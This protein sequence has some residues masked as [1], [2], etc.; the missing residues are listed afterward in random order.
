MAEEL[1]NNTSTQGQGSAA[2]TE[3]TP[4]TYTEAELQSEVD[5]RVT[6]AMKTAEKKNA[7]KVKE[8]ERLATMNADERYKYDLEQREKAIAEKEKAL[9]MAENKNAACKVLADKGLDL[10][11]VDFVVDESADVMND[12]IKVLERA[13]RNSVKAEVE[14]R[15]GGKSPAAGTVPTGEI[16]KETFKKMGL[17]ERENLYNTDPE[18]YKKLKS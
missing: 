12:R 9:A 5:R 16:T 4:K 17:S 14:K 3:N 10:S 13:F 7:E 18:L 11:L 6:Q 15:I 2:E 1:N 8:A